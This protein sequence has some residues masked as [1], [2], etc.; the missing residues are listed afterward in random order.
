MAP[1]SAAVKALIP[2]SDRFLKYPGRANA[3]PDSEG[4][5][6]F[7]VDSAEIDIWGT[8]RLV[9]KGVRFTPTSLNRH[10]WRNSLARRPCKARME[11]IKTVKFDGIQIALSEVGTC[12]GNRMPLASLLNIALNSSQRHGKH[13]EDSDT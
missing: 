10:E 9:G 4:L 13:P 12:G 5:A 6:T 8:Y 2:T 1:M 3:T 7:I 11:R